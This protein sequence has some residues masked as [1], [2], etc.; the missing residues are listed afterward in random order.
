M[1]EGQAKERIRQMISFVQ[2]EAK[3]KAREIESKTEH[4]YNNAKAKF[5]HQAKEK[6][7]AEYDK[8]WKQL[9]IQKRIAHSAAINSARMEVMKARTECMVSL[10]EEARFKVHEKNQKDQNSYKDIL[11]QLIVE[12]L[13]KLLDT[14]VKIHCREVDVSIVSSAVDEAKARYE[15][16]MLEETGKNYTVNLEVADGDFLPPPPEKGVNTPSCCGGV[17]LQSNAGKIRCINTLDKRIEMAYEASVP[18][19]R[20]I[21][22]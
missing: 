21:I 2:E 22:F 3:E 8:K 14:E 11:T 20:K 15:E 4:E 1:N 13:I 18:H 17:I 10:L 12:G 6:L 16:I 9:E 5:L 19:L 7:S